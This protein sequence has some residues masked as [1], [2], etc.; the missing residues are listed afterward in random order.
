MTLK[1]QKREQIININSANWKI[2]SM[3]HYATL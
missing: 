2:K 1:V 3:R